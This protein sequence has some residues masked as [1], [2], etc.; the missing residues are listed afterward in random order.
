MENYVKFIHFH[1]DTEFP[2]VVDSWIDTSSLVYSR[3]IRPGEKAILHSSIGEWQIHSMMEAKDRGIW[4]RRG[5]E[6]CLNLGKFWSMAS[7]SGEYCSM[8]HDDLFDCIYSEYD[9]GGDAKGMIRLVQKK[10]TFTNR[11]GCGEWGMV[12]E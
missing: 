7:A 5:L 10:N 3:K 12:L 1:N 9:T 4:I 6:D 8:E 2:I 11:N